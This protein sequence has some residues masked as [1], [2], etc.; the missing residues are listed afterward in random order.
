M[1]DGCTNEEDE[2]DNADGYINAD[3]GRATDGGGI[4]SIWCLS[5]RH[6]LLKLSI[7]GWHTGLGITYALWRRHVDLTIVVSQGEALDLYQL[8]SY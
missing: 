7:N 3:G 4:R 1:P 5:Q 8:D 6:V 2:E